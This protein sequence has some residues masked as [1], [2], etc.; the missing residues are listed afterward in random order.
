VNDD[1]EGASNGSRWIC[2]KDTVALHQWLGEKI[3]EHQRQ[4]Q[5][6]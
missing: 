1:V 3:K 2:W 6:T 4:K 5:A